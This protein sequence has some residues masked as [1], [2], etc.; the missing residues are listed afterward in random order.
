M[1]ALVVRVSAGALLIAL[2]L[3][4]ALGAQKATSIPLRPK[5]FAGADTNDARLYYS[6]GVQSLDEKPAESVRAFY[7]ASKLDPSSAEALY[8]LHAATML[9]MTPD[10]LGRYL[11]RRDKTR[12]PEYL[13][14]DSLLYRAFTMNPFLTRTMERQLKQRSIEA[15][16]VNSNPSIDRVRL[17]DAILTHMRAIRN[18][19]EMA[20]A[21]GRLAE[22]LQAY[23]KELSYKGFTSEQREY[24]AT[25][26]HSERGLL[27]YRLG[28]LDSSRAEMTAAVQEMR[29][30]EE[31]ARKRVVLYISKAMFEHLIGIIDERLGQPDKAREAYEQALQEDLSYYGAH[32]SLAAMSIAKGDTANALLEMDLAVQ[33]QPLDPVL[34]YDYAKML[35]TARRDGEAAAQLMKSIAADPYYAAPHML[36]ARIADVEQ[37]T[38]DALREYQQYTTLA[39]KSDPQLSV[40]RQRV[41]A[42]TSSVASA[43]AP[44]TP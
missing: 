20:A 14:I 38:D 43:P 37:Y 44:A 29:A 28:N 19:G 27:F 9:A 1:T 10:E 5:L 7:W 35:V 17:N 40:A 3:S 26:I 31:D 12:R 24:V 6:Y 13:A 21:D 42:L 36:L 2:V 34:R 39:A 33:L 4:P 22:A 30:R 25:F 41:T 11:D 15:I 16:I 18:T 23:A 8:A 32:R